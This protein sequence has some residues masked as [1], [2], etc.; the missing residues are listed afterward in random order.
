MSTQRCDAI[1]MTGP[2]QGNIC[3]R[4]CKTQ[5]RCGYHR[6]KSVPLEQQPMPIEQQPMPIEQQPMPIEQQS[7][8][9]VVIQRIVRG[10]IVSYRTKSYHNDISMFLQDD[11]LSISVPVTYTIFND[12]IE[13]TIIEEFKGLYEWY[14]RQNGNKTKFKCIHTTID[15]TDKQN[16]TLQKSFSRILHNRQYMT[17]ELTIKSTKTLYIRIY[18][19]CDELDSESF[20][21]IFMRIFRCLD[22]TMMITYVN[23][24]AWHIRVSSPTTVLVDNKMIN[25]ILTRVYTTR[26]ILKL[27]ESGEIVS[28]NGVNLNIDSLNA[29]QLQ[30]L[31]IEIRT[32]YLKIYIASRL[33]E[34]CTSQDVLDGA[35][36][37]LIKDPHIWMYVIKGCTTDVNITELNS[38]DQLLN[39]HVIC[40]Y[41]QTRQLA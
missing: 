22:T 27:Y 25:Y 34:Y 30:T 28:K 15:L 13:L 7:N 17:V 6:I 37:E 24:L 11:I 12:G 26:E 20:N 33:K 40:N 3:N 18:D 35:R 39:Y 8:S 9:V 14:T 16:T 31:I 23:E 32:L 19:I 21:L 29:K 38:I 4:I 10:F 5:G 41:D 2:R 36:L 1:I